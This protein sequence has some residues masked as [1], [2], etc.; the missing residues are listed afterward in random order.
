MHLHE[1]LEF[2]TQLESF[3]NNAKLLKLLKY[4]VFVHIFVVIIFHFRIPVMFE[5]EDFQPVVV[6][7]PKEEDKEENQSED[8]KKQGENEE[9]GE[10]KS[11]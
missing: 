5:V 4:H 3:Y 1:W 2:C 7:E 8:V 9:A 11:A 10:V 6:E